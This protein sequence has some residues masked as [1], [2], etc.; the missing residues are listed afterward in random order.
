VADLQRE[1]V[2]CQED[3]TQKQFKLAQVKGLK[4]HSSVEDSKVIEQ[5]KTKVISLMNIIN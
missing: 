2:S 1:L 4:E 5:L 3:L